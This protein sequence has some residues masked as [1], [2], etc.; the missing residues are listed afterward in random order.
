MIF[1]EQL[2]TMKCDRCK[3]M[4]CSEDSYNYSLDV[5]SLIEDAID[6]GWININSKHY[7]EKCYDPE[8]LK[9]YDA[10]PGYVKGI[11]DFVYKILKGTNVQV[12]ENEVGFITIKFDR[13][14][15]KNEV[16]EINYIK[17]RLGEKFVSIDCKYEG[18]DGYS[19]TCFIKMKN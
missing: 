17:D 8:T 13:Y 11:I 5:Q 12:I 16:F 1:S 3:E 2:F 19:F 14:Q 15:S 18:F 6:S 10:F 4:L 9:P 7:C